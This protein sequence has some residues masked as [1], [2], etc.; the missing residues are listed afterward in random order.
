MNSS[1][2]TGI[3]IMKFGGTSVG[4]VD[5]LKQSAGDRREGRPRMARM[6]LWWSPP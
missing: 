5:A 4:S 6:W 3:L 2:K 1:A